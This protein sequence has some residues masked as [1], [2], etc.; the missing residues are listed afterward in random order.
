MEKGIVFNIQRYSLHD[1]PGIRTI[2]FLKGCPLSCLWCSNP[3]SQK[4]SRQI[5]FKPDSCAGC[6]FCF[7][8]CPIGARKNKHFSGCIYCG[9]C[10]NIC[11]TGA[12]EMIGNEMSVKEVVDEVERDRAFYNNSKGG[13]SLSGGEPLIQ[14]EFTAALLDAIKKIDLHVA[15]ET[16]GFGPWE[17]AEK[18]LSGADLILYDLKQMDSRIHK[19]YTGVS[20]KLILDNARR[21]AKTKSNSMIFRVPF[22]GSVNNDLKNIVEVAKFANEVGVNE[23]HL[24]PYHRYGEGKYKKL[25]LEYTFNAFTPGSTAIDEALSLLRSYGI[26]AK[27]GG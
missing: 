2:V 19:K 26:N 5:V 20:N 11:P 27:N 4:L 23:V 22:I 14:H 6:G 1:G 15:I 12:L 25:G 3:E 10:I 16:T 24:L 18:I 7:N 21:I 8:V 17:H 9:K 13:I